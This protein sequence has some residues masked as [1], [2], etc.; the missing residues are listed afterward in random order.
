MTHKRKKPLHGAFIALFDILGLGAALVVFAYFHHVM[1]RSGGDPITIATPAP[2]APSAPTPTPK[3]YL[4]SMLDETASPYQDEP[5]STP[6]PTAAPI[7]DFSQTF[8]KKAA[9]GGYRSYQ[10]DNISVNVEQVYRDKVTYYCAD[11]YI[12][13][14]AYLKTA[15]ADD[16]F[17]T[18]HSDWPKNIAAD[19]NAII[20]INGDYYGARQSGLVIRNGQLYRDAMRRD[21][22]LLYLDG[23]METYSKD[24]FNL[25]DAISR[26]AYQS[27]AF[28]PSLLDA[29]GHALTKFESRVSGENPR[30]A[31]GYYAPGHYCF[32]VVDGRQADSEGMTLAE[33][34]SLMELLGC[35]VAYNL[36]GGATAT[37]VFEGEVINEPS[38]GGRASSDI[39]YIGY[40]ADSVQGGN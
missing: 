32:V 3:P 24:D 20:A 30:C 18:G 40:G 7:G 10:D 25:D 11:I 29:Q 28:G 26:G 33:L 17:G 8:P 12:R 34:A 15:F 5:V 16:T 14:I 19:N 22:L 37:M 2:V 35:K 1:P 21:V 4:M 27:W 13:N 39:I 31:I 9:T 6:E 38:G 23:T 36:D